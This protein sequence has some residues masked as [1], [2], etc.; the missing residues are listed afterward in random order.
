MAALT[1]V[2][3]SLTGP[4]TAMVAAAGGG[5]T[6]QNTGKE[7]FLIRN[8]DAAPHDVTFDSPGTCDFAAAANAAHDNV[9]TVP[10]G[11]QRIIGPFPVTRF[12]DGN[13]NV[14]VTYSAVT[15]VTVAVIRPA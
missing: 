15:S 9:V 14:S 6:F 13:G 1:P 2:T 8:A 5:D 12:N 7:Y 3:P 11:E 10:A 4:S